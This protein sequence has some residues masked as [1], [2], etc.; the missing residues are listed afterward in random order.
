MSAVRDALVARALFDRIG[1]LLTT[2][3]TPAEHPSQA[4]RRALG[5]RAS[6]DDLEDELK[7]YLARVRAGRA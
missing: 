1:Q 4:T 6:L 5:V 2:L 3:E 7:A